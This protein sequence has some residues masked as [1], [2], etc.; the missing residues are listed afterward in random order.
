M[1]LHR[2]LVPGIGVRGQEISELNLF[3]N[4]I[5][6]VTILIEIEVADCSDN[7]ALLQPGFLGCR[8][9]LNSSDINSAAISRFACVLAQLGITR[10]KI[11]DTDRGKSSVIWLGC[12]L[13]KMRNNRSWN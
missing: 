13:E 12:V 9:R 10:G 6:V 5:H 4:R 3:I 1:N 2:H 11:I 7:I 8:A